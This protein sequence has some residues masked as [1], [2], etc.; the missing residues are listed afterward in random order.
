MQYGIEILLQCSPREGM[1][2]TNCGQRSVY[3]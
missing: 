1:D 2:Q 3:E